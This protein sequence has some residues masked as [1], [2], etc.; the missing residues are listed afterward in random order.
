MP[1]PTLPLQAD[2]LLGAL[3][4]FLVGLG[5]GGL[6]AMGTFGVP[7]LALAMSPIRAAAILLPVFV[8]SDVFAL[9][10]YR[11]EFSARNLRILIPAATL[12]IGT[13]WL[14]AAHLSDASV[15]ILIGVL[16]LGFCANS[17]RMRG[18]A[19]PPHAADLPRGAL[20]GSVL[21]F[22]S[23]V[24]HAGAP[25][26]QIYVLPQRLPKLVYAGTSA[27]TFAAVNALKLIPYAA[28]GQLSAP[29]LRLSA[30]LL[31]PALVGTG[32]GMK[33]V[34]VIPERAYYVFLQVALFVI[35]VELIVKGLRS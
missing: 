1:D 3:A 21:G 19:A 11:R 20:W 10:L 26:F 24:S 28:L 6:A 31:L 29:N 34:R 7:V 4:A 13:G 25:P 12:G 32:V 35:S 5:K 14:F 22:A 9:W 2:L 15:G 23:F 8:F 17:W 16:G 27:I 33:A 18:R 30:A